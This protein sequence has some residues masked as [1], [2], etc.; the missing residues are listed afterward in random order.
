[1]CGRYSL[2]TGPEYAELMELLRQVEEQNRGEAFKTGEIFPTNKVPVL[3]GA[4]EA[5]LSVWGFPHFKGSGVIINAR[6]ETAPQKRMFQKPLLTQRCVVPSTGFY[7]WKK[8]EKQ[9][10]WFTLPQSSV[11]YMAGFYNVFEGEKRFVILTTEGNASIADVHHRMPV[12]LP[13]AHLADWIGNTDFA[14]R[15]LQAS[16]P[17]LERTAVE[18]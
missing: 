17:A 16:M 9:K 6:A 10:Y 3:F 4:Q 14:L 7:E 5:G 15:Y 18:G 2:F 12:V 11:L 13:Q 1:M 8:P